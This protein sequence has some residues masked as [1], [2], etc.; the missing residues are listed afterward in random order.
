MET[1]PLPR[2]L[3]KDAVL[4]VNAHSRKGQDLFAQAKEKLEQAGMRLIAA[5]AVEQP[6]KMDAM[7]SGPSE[8]HSNVIARALGSTSIV[9]AFVRFIFASR[10]PSSLRRVD[11]N[12]QCTRCAKGSFD[13]MNLRFALFESIEGFPIDRYH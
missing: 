4:V 7:Y 6:E 5:H 10:F 2:P 11:E 8:N 3:P 12:I 1:K 13:R 9:M